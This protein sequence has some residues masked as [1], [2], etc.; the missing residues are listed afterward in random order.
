ME[1][2]RGLAAAIHTKLDILQVSGEVV[3]E[4]VEGWRLRRQTRSRACK[5][6]SRGCGPENKRPLALAP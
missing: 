6:Y 3:A 4:M 1:L 5:T 2:R